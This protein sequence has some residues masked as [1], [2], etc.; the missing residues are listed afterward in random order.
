MVHIFT[1]HLLKSY[2][3]FIACIVGEILCMCFCFS[4]KDVE[5]SSE[6]VMAFVKNLV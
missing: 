4:R 6:D 5:I 3:L 1:F 2:S